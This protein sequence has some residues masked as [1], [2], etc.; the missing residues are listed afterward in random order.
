[1]ASSPTLCNKV[2][3]IVTFGPSCTSNAA[4][5]A[6]TILTTSTALAGTSVIKKLL[7]LETMKVTFKYPA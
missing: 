3:P 6:M 1:M 7:A 2:D 5:I 4:E